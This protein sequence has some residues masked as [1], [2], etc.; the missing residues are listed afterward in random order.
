VTVT[1]GTDTNGSP[2]PVQAHAEIPAIFTVLP[3]GS[4]SPTTVSVPARL[5]IELTVV[6]HDGHRHVAVLRSRSAHGLTVHGLTVPA[7]GRA[8]VLVSG[9]RPGR[10]ALELDGANRGAL[11]VGVGPGP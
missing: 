3:S 8:S 2:P 7:G 1:V 4:L 9:L 6:S 10:Y 5:A 11:V